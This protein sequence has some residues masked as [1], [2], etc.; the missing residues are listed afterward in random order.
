MQF[1][2]PM[3]N[4]AL[5]MVCENGDRLQPTPMQQFFLRSAP[6]LSIRGHTRPRSRLPLH[7]C[8]HFADKVFHS[9]SK[10]AHSDPKGGPPPSRVS[11][12]LKER[13]ARQTSTTTSNGS[14]GGRK[15]SA[16]DIQMVQGLIERCLQLYMARKVGNATWNP[17]WYME[18]VCV[19]TPRS[20]TQ[21]VH[22]GRLLRRSAAQ[23]MTPL[24]GH[25]GGCDCA[26]RC[27]EAQHMAF[28]SGH[29]RMLW[30]RCRSRPRLSL[31]SQT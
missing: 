27:C 18:G 11:L 20:S 23:G 7:R 9:M 8:C 5:A 17:T 6:A 16:S 25:G 29:C 14:D 15:V 4:A 12:R 24:C 2:K 13:E 28:P 31:G 21:L 3:R 19:V 22:G 10:Q 26:P 30:Q 1:Q